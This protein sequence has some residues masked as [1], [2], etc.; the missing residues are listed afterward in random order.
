[1]GKRGPAPQPKKIAEMKGVYRPV[2]HA[3]QV[4]RSGGLKFLTSVP[5]APEYLEEKAQKVWYSHLS[6]MVSVG[7]WI[8]TTDLATFE[9]A[10]DAFN[11]YLLYRDAPMT[12]VS[13]HG[14]PKTSA[15][16]QVKKEAIKTWLNYQREF[17]WSPSA[18]TRIKLENGEETADD[19]AD[20]QL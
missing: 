11:T 6:Q 9:I 14:S 8:A 5:E 16:F 4:E 1:M 10:I 18:R 17:G 3:D 7:G 20:L 13:Q 15:E 12:S 2:R 19:L